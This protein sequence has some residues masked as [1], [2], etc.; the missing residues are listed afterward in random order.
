[1]IS[2]TSTGDSLATMRLSVFDEAPYRGLLKI[3]RSAD[4][5]F[6]NLEMLT[7][8]Y[9][10][11]PSAES[12]G[13]YVVGPPY[14]AEELRWM[15]FNLYARANNHTLDYGDRGLIATSA[16]LDRLGLIHAGAGRNLGEERAP[17]Y[18][19][20]KNGRV[21]LISMSSTFA[22]FGRAGHSRPDMKGRPGLNPLRYETK[23]VIKKETMAHLRMMFKDLGIAPK[24]EK[25]GVTS[26]MNIR[27]AVG[28][29]AIITTPNEIDAKEI[30][31]SIRDAKRQADY[32][33]V[34]LHSHEPQGL[35]R[36]APAG[37]I[38]VFCR[39]CIDEGADAVMGHGPHVLRGIEIYKKKPIMYSLGNFIFQNETIRFL[40]RDIYDKY[41]LAAEATPAD[42][43]DIRGRDGKPD[44]R[45][46]KWFTY[47]P[48]Y[49]EAVVS[50]FSLDPN[51]VSDFEL[52]PITL[53]M[54]KPR[55]QRGRPILA[56]GENA[57]RILERLQKMS[58]Q[59]NTRIKI[60]NSVGRVL[61]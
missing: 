29:P 12:G 18:L 27:F 10:G 16:V 55:S 50:R 47:D 17:A 11:H 39:R 19:E 46:Y 49:W 21:A 13:T 15:G 51:G 31:K 54:E 34:S 6:T 41:G 33:L 14:M 59:F 45:G 61:V 5:S 36:E 28:K 60:E 32:V 30:S 56:E 52:H 20:T 57:K 48:L 53:G 44:D 7:T 1:M 4:V 35:N 58:L 24:K 3:I 37:F 23:L 2:V 8:D 22:S 43:Y 42:L 9:D 40:P 38:P 25:G 26:F